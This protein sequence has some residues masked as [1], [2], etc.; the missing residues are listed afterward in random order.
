[1]FSRSRFDSL[2]IGARIASAESLM[3]GMSGRDLGVGLVLTGDIAQPA[4][5]ADVTAANLAISGVTVQGLHASGEGRPQ[6]ARTALVVNARA[7]RVGGLPDGFD[8]LGQDVSAQ[9]RLVL[10]HGKL[11]GNLGLRSSRLQAG[12]VLASSPMGGPWNGTVTARADRLAVGG[13]GVLD[14]QADASLTRLGGRGAS[15]AGRL[16][17]RSLSLDSPEARDLLGGQANAATAFALAPDGTLSVS[18]ATLSAPK[19]RLVSTRAQ[20]GPGGAVSIAADAVSEAYGPLKVAVSGTRAAPTAHLLAANPKVAGITGLDARLAGLGDGKWRIEAAGHSP[21]GP[22][23]LDA[24]VGLVGNL[25][26]ADIRRASL[27][28]LTVSGQVDQT[29]AGPFAG[30]LRI[31]GAGLSGGATLSAAQG[32]QAIDLNLDAKGARLPIAPPLTLTSGQAQARILLKKGLPAVSGKAY[33]RGVRW[34]GITLAEAKVDGHWDR[35]GEVNLAVK[36]RGAAPFDFKGHASLSPELAQLTGSG[37]AGGVAVRLADAAQIR[38]DARGWRLTPTT[39]VLP[40]GRLVLAGQLGG[41]GLAGSARLEQVDLAVANGFDPQLGLSGAANGVVSFNLANGSPPTGS[42]QLEISRFTRASLA[43]ESE[44]LDIAVL[45][46]LAPRQGLAHAVVRRRGAV[47]GRLQATLGPFGADG[48]PLQRVM[49]APLHGGVRF[50]G[51]A[52][53]LWSLAGFTGQNLSGPLAIGADVSGTV[54]QPTVVG[55]AKGQNLRYVNAG[56]GTSIDDIQLDGRF[57]G[58]RLQIDRLT[59]RAGNGTVGVSG[60]IDLSE[61]NGYP[62]DLKLSLS[63]ARLARSDQVSVTASGDLTATNSRKSGALISGKLTLD[64]A[65]Y[66]IGQS[67][68]ETVPQLAGVRRKDEPLGAPI[69][70]SDAEASQAGPPSRWKLDVAISSSNHLRVRGMGL[71]A[72]WA[73]GLSIKGDVRHPIVIGDITSV[74]GDFNFAGRQLTLTRGLIHLNGSSPPDP[75]LDIVASSNVEG[76][77]AN[78]SISGTSEHPQ[79][80]FS[81]TPALPQEEVLARLL[82]GTSAANISPA[83]AVELAASINTLRGGGGGPLGRVQKMAGL[84]RLQFY[85]ADQATGRAA[86]VGAGKYVTKNIYLEIT[87]DVRGY[88]ATQIQVALR[89]SLQL[90]SQVS[91]VGTSNLSLRFTHNY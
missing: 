38:H 26:R 7:A 68:A 69:T 57:E 61:A 60:F 21:Y 47:V 8:T 25:A 3:K 16:R 33:A 24:D 42:A 20:L 14:V 62:I 46:S 78:V 87:T 67:G 48:D 5:A 80:V 54:D 81:S 29:Q 75:L 40:Q 71:S 52:E 70:P 82:F 44:P 49:A 53:A 77:T 18:G 34:N 2:R 74:S 28:G 55:V 27:R 45:A 13:V 6:G 66:Q 51:P 72:V 12:L 22:L 73:A 36:G 64:D 85:A 19:F 59:G 89:R 37:S 86:G 63:R 43:G 76:V 23:A 91:A 10:T 15:V 41:T 1:D 31:V 56:V 4:F 50:N 90:L 58:A 79:I 9:A 39:V 88:T 83:Q 35:T 11:S 84:D 30:R 32:L 65:S 17:A